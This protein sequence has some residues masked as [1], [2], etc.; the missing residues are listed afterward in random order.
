VTGPWPAVSMSAQSYSRGPLD[1]SGHAEAL[2]REIPHAELPPLE[3][4]CHQM[5]PRAWWSSVIPAMLRHTSGGWEA[6]GDRLA[7]RSIAAGDPTGWFD[8]L[9]RGSF[10]MALGRRSCERQS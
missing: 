5:P 7:S 3:G 10:P 2:A 8:R 1:P 6:Q 9:S 4:V